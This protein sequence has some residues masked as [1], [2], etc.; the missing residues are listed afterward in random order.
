MVASEFF[1]LRSHV[2][3]L[4]RVHVAFPTRHALGV[5]A[6]KHHRQ[7][8]GID[9]HLA[10]SIIIRDATKRARLESLAEHAVTVR[11]PKKNP[12]LIAS[13]V[14]ED[15]KVT[16]KRV[17]PKRADDQVA[18]AIEALAKIDWFRRHEEANARG[19]AQHRS[20]PP[21]TA[22]SA[23]GSTCPKTRRTTPLGI[24]NSIR[25]TPT[26]VGS[27]LCDLD[28]VPE[29]GALST[30]CS[31]WKAAPSPLVLLSLRDQ[32]SSELGLIPCSSAYFFALKPLDCHTAMISRHC[33]SLR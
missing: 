17:H 24:I 13:T 4:E 30:T 1:F 19:Q 18:K 28:V 22:A 33:S 2:F 23:S 11:V 16:Q 8:T 3:I 6:S 20:S 15:E 21:M 14:D 9:L 32:D 26:P 25:P 10:P 31:G 12:N 7:V 29:R 27:V 5:N